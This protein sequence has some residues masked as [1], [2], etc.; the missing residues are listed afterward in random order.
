MRHLL[1]FVLSCAVSSFALGQGDTSPNPD[2]SSRDEVIR[3]TLVRQKGDITA[4][5]ATSRG[6]GVIIGYAS[7]ALV[8]C[9]GEE[10]CREFEGTPGGAVN[11]PVTDIAVAAR[12]GQD[13]IWVAY[14]HGVFYRCVNYTCRQASP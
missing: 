9:S 7:G 5:E 14:P 4:M 2:K 13:I 3:S 11:S 8:S 12:D 10:N 1:V 6:G